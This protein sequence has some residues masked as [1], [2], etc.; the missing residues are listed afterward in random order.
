MFRVF[1]IHENGIQVVI[2]FVFR[3]FGGFHR[4]L[5][6]IPNVESIPDLCFGDSQRFLKKCVECVNRN[7][8]P[9]FFLESYDRI[10]RVFR[11]FSPND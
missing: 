8:F 7:E 9:I 3:A 1:T 10:V 5:S 2:P 11:G 6:T 4:T